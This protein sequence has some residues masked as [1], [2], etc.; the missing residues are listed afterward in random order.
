MAYF[1]LNQTNMDD[2]DQDLSNKIGA[3]ESAPSFTTYR[4]DLLLQHVHPAQTY[5]QLGSQT[6][7]NMLYLQVSD[8]EIKSTSVGEMID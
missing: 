6:E 8:V 1:S 4:S 5:G 2:E 7:S 3:Y